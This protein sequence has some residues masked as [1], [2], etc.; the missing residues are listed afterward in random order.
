[1]CGV[2]S[3][4]DVTT[5]TPVVLPDDV[6]GRVDR[7]VS[8]NGSSFFI[9]DRR[10]FG[11]G[12]NGEGQ[13]GLGH[14]NYVN[15]PTELPIPVND[16]IAYCSLTVIR[17]GDTLLACGDNRHGQILSEL[18]NASRQFTSPTNVK[19]PGSVVKVVVDSESI[20]AQL[21]DGSWVGQGKYVSGCFAMYLVR[22]VTF[23]R[24]RKWA[25]ICAEYINRL[26]VQ[27]PGATM[28][29]WPSKSPP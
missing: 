10:C 21:K 14:T 28:M 25:P 8:C 11:C 7:V 13:L 27:E 29:L 22:K 15:A 16:I 24:F 26:D 4:D 2:G 23:G 12:S 18:S 20:C 17:S 1:M 5:L 6:R 19:L 9:T 3:T